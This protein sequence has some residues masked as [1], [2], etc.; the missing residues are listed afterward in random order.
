MRLTRSRCD[1]ERGGDVLCCNKLQSG[2]PEGIDDVRDRWRVAGVNVSDL[3]AG[4]SVAVAVVALV[5]SYVVS[6]KQADIQRAQGELQKAQAIENVEEDKSTAI[7]DLQLAL[8]KAAANPSGFG[9]IMPEI[10][11]LALRADALLREPNVEAYWFDYAILGYAFAQVWDNE[12]AA[13]S[14]QLA[15]EHAGSKA[16]RLY[17]LRG[18]AEYLYNVGDLASGRQD[19]GD[20]IELLGGEHPSQDVDTE[21]IVLLNTQQAG[22]E[23]GAGATQR[24]HD[25]MVEACGRCAGLDAP[26]RRLRSAV[27]LV[28]AA[29]QF[30]MDASQLPLP[31][32][33]LQ[34][35]MATAQLK[36]SRELRGAPTSLG[37]APSSSSISSISS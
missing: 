11:G 2:G 15:V 7:H 12:N 3:I 4:V 25:R 8:A 1:R 35:A 13:R 20:A 23:F 37:A 30:G 5:L 24:A 6:R 31:A 21:Q 9:F 32:N 33:L 17:T 28:R 14:W 36:A 27:W 26:W 16:S 10:Q 19:F 29:T 34:E 18:R 22:L